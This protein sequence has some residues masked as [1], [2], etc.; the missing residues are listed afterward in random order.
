[1]YEVKNLTKSPV[2]IVIKSFATKNPNS[3]SFMKPKRFTTLNIF[4]NKREYISDE[5]VYESH[6]ETLRKKGLISY[7]YLDDKL[8]S[9]SINKH[10]KKN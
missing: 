10:N 5:R 9:Q 3:K 7:R 1:M 8:V 6:L 2:Q 4:G